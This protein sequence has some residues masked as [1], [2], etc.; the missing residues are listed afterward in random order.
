ML[1]SYPKRIFLT[2]YTEAGYGTDYY[3]S[4][5]QWQRIYRRE[6]SVFNFRDIW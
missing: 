6:F 3:L 5:S 2:Q 1:F 4:W